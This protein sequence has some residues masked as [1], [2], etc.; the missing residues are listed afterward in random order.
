MILRASFTKPLSEIT[1]KDIVGRHALAYLKKRG[2]SKHDILKYNI[3]YC[4]GGAFDKMI[5]IPSYN[6]EGKLNEDVEDIFRIINY[7]NKTQ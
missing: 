5:V 7:N 1:E 6:N 3:G 4:D 2:V